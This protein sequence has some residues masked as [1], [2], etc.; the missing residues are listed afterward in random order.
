VRSVGLLVCA[1]GAVV[2]GVFLASLT[3]IGSNSVGAGYA[4][5]CFAAAFL[6]GAVMTGGRGSFIGA[7]L[8]A[9]FLA[10]LDNVTPLLNIPNATQQTLYGAILLIAV[11]TYAV[12][13]RARARRGLS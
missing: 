8:G 2:A 10:L 7:V 13:Q 12:V 9:I 11:G 1:F 5:P 6:G 3:G 4:L